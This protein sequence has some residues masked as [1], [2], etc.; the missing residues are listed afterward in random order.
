[1]FVVEN[2]L[3]NRLSHRK[4]TALYSVARSYMTVLLSYISR[5]TLS[6]DASEVKNEI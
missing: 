2:T 6:K 3:H 4:I 5:Q 1:M